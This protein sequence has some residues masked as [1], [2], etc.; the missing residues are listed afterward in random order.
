MKKLI[1]KGVWC[2]SFV[3]FFNAADAQILKRV[4]KQL[5]KKAEKAIDKVL[6]G[7]QE[8]TDGKKAENDSAHSGAA[9]TG[10]FKDLPAGTYDFASGKD[11]VFFDGFNQ[12]TE[13]KMASRWTSNG[14]GTTRTLSAF[15]GNWLQLYNENTYKIK[16]LIR[17]PENFTLEFD[18]LVLADDQ[19]DLEINFGFDHQKGISNHYYLA[20]R[21][22]INIEASYRFNRF[23]FT[24]NELGSRKS[25]DVDARMSYLVN[26]VMKVQIQIVGDHMTA[27][28][29]KF[30]VLDTEMVDPQTKKYFYIA[31]DSDKNKGEVFIDN[32]HISAL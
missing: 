1:L 26:D 3:F 13:G 12:E 30:K 19:D 32:V 10:P 6:D 16:D 28:I 20:E 24:S 31:V 21:N 5:E 15:E 18:L 22:P 4:G 14:R 17:I 27:Y 29:N 11:T 9:G 23:S 7:K 2:A 25:S 8:E